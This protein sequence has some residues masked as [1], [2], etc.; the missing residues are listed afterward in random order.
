M[1]ESDAAHR[2]FNSTI[3][4]VLVFYGT[5]M[6]VGVNQ[7]RDIGECCCSPCFLWNPYASLASDS[8]ESVFCMLQSLFF[9]EP[10]CET[11]NDGISSGI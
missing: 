2:V 9:M 11:G 1:R 8:L 3:V 6:R 10:L 5:L 4:A 7:P